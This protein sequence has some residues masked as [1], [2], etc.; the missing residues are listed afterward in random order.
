[1]KYVRSVQWFHIDWSHFSCIQRVFSAVNMYNHDH[2]GDFNVSVC[3]HAVE[4]RMH[5]CESLFNGFSTDGAFRK[6][7]QFAFDFNHSSLS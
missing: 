1:M 6:C 4:Y 5:E 7:T 2:C 3:Q